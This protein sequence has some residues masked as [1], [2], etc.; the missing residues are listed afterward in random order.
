[1]T[2]PFAPCRALCLVRQHF[3]SCFTAVEAHHCWCFR[4]RTGGNHRHGV[5]LG[6]P[7]VAELQPPEQ[8]CFLPTPSAARRLCPEH[9]VG[10]LRL[11]VERVGGG[12]HDDAPAQ[13]ADK[14]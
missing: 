11:L 8:H 6:P 9:L 3:P 10:F 12:V 5:Q 14:G 1:M 7:T 2:G 13:L 4:L